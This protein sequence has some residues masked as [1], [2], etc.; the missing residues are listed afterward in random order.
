[1]SRKRFLVV[2]LALASAAIF[3]AG[4]QPSQAQTP[5]QQ[6]MKWRLQC[7]V[8]PGMAEYDVTVPRMIEII[9]KAS[10]GRIDIKLF[11]A[12]ALMSSTD[13][14]KG[15]AK[16]VI[17]MGND[18]AAYWMGLIPIGEFIAGWPFVFESWREVLAFE[19]NYGAM[20]IYQR[21]AA[22]HN[23]RLLGYHVGPPYWSIMSNKPVRRLAD[24][25]GLKI[26]T[27][28][29]AAKLYEEQGASIVKLPP[30]D[31]YAALSTG[32]INA[33][34]FSSP[35]GFVGGKF[36]EVTKYYVDPSW[37]IYF[38]GGIIINLK[39]WNSLG[40]DLKA[41]LS[42]AAEENARYYQ[43]ESCYRDL[44]AKQTM[45]SKGITFTEYPKEDL[46]KLRKRSFEILQEKA[47]VDKYWAELVPK[48][49]DFLKKTGRL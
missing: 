18:M 22:E 43:M 45:M 48:V 19:E 7:Y 35:Q 15:V 10:G 38:G 40:D 41:I 47:K 5:K 25:K 14:H 33:L 29:A 42:M 30:E 4:L 46:Q 36:H 28:G 27:W 12:G 1:M 9:K 44:T 13:I 3:I 6:V 24:V 20:E 31:C 21:A 37:T 32:T 2:T 49:M 11:P 16:G 23:F 34:T 26:R 17:E 8:G 39:L